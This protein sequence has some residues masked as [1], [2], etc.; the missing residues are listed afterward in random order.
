M[1]S[2]AGRRSGLAAPT[3]SVV[4]PVY[5]HAHVVGRAIES[6]LQQTVPPQEIV[7]VDDCSEDAMELARALEPWIRDHG[8]QLH[9]TPR[10]SGPAAARNIGIRA[11]S[12]ALVALLDA[13]DRHEPDHLETAV[14][15]LL[16][17]PET[18]MTCADAF[19]EHRGERLPGRKNDQWQP[20]EP[21]VT[22]ERLLEGNCIS[23]LTVVMRRE[24]FDAFGPF[25]EAPGLVGVE[26]YDLWLRVSKSRTIRYV[27][28]PLASYAKSPESISGD[29]RRLY[30][31]EAA[32]FDKLERVMDGFQES[33]GAVAS[34]RRHEMRVDLAYTLCTTRDWGEALRA[35]AV[36]VARRPTSAAAYR[37]FAR[38][39]LRR[40]QGEVHS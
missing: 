24:T 9:R 18:A 30:R 12:G 29:P 39:L 14:E 5:N 1:A 17:H 15:T 7:V 37:V 3:V 36:A 38:A 22:F 20:I 13:D 34:R 33:H 26:D 28:R 11:S 31:G 16:A 23:T 19:Q 8:V 21:I 10:N 27:D 25:D 6:A 40:T 35:A 4:I 2:A 32:V